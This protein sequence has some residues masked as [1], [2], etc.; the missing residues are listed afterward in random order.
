MM[1]GMWRMRE[2]QAARVEMVSHCRVCLR[3]CG[4]AE[5]ALGI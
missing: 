5:V 1:G 3:S 2:Y 4:K